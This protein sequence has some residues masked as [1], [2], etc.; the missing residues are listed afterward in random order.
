MNIIT[1]GKTT[2]YFLVFAQKE[3]MIR[4]PSQL[5]KILKGLLEN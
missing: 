4:E 1:M 2:A 3:S 5:L